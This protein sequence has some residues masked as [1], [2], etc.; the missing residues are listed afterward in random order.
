MKEK[1]Q[2]FIDTYKSEDDV[3]ICEDMFEYLLSIKEQN[4][5]ME[6]LSVVLDD[7]DLFSIGEFALVGLMMGL[8]I[9]S[10]D[11]VFNNKSLMFGNENN[12]NLSIRNKFANRCLEELEIKDGLRMVF[13]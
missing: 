5:L 3:D 1:I 8:N 2:N 9:I 7:L 13:E 6:E 4:D 10:N 11:I 12:S